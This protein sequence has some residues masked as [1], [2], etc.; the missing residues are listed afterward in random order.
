MWPTKYRQRG[1][2]HFRIVLSG[3]KVCMRRPPDV[4]NEYFYFH[5][6]ISYDFDV[7]VPFTIFQS[8]H[9]KALNVASFQLQ[10]NSCA[11]AKAF[12]VS[13]WGLII[14]FIV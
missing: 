3:D 13:C 10:P 7:G 6:R 8:E 2:Y 11:F 5:P 1:Q 12:K 14:T 4:P 9:L